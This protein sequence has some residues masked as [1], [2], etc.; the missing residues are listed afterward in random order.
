MKQLSYKVPRMNLRREERKGQFL[1]IVRAL[2]PW[3]TTSKIAR[4][5]GMRPST[6]VLSILDEMV[7][8]GVLST[9]EITLPNGFKA[10][11]FEVRGERENG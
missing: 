2:Q 5:A 9:S 10:Y 3:A 7:E 6:H 4:R 8:E 11:L 1:R